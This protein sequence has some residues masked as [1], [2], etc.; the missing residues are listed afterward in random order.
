MMELSTHLLYIAIFLKIYFLGRKNSL[1]WVFAIIADIGWIAV[2]FLLPLYS[3]V[4]W[5]LGFMVMSIIGY[6]NWKPSSKDENVSVPLMEQLEDQHSKEIAALEARLE[7]CD[8][9]LYSL[10]PTFQ[11]CCGIMW[12]EE[13]HKETCKYYCKICGG[14]NEHCEC[15][16]DD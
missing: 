12:E 3:M 5:H 10:S 1:G 13:Q 16:Y 14:H 11:P 8:C 9:R 4:I 6:R 15:P 7:D 2:G